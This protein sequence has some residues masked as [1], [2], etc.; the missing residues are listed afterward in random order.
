[1]K[2]FLGVSVIVLLFASVSTATADAK[3][4]RG[5]GKTYVYGLCGPNVC[6][7][8][9]KTRRSKIVL[10]RSSKKEY[11]SIAASPS[12]STLAFTY[13]GELF[14]SGR[15]GRGRRELDQGGFGPSQVAVSRNGRDVSWF[16]NVSSQQ[17]FYDPISGF[18]TCYPVTYTYL[19]RQGLSDRE[20][21]AL[22]GN[23]FTAGWYRGQ[24]MAQVEPDEGTED[25]ICVLDDEGDCGRTLAARPGRA[26]SSPSTSPDGRYL[27]VVSEPA[28]PEEGDMDYEGRIEIF[29]AANGTHIRNLTTGRK[30]DTPIFSPD[31]KSVAFNRGDDVLS[32]SVRGGKQKLIKRDMTLTGPSWARGK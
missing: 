8:D 22:S 1:M 32:R 25:Y 21:D 16:A 27:A 29:N 2:A 31:G 5:G 30:D 6:R 4:K 14:R 18:P 26:Y 20:S 28:P 12:G 17:C 10:R 13:D 7:V 15:D 11:R 23:Q 19:F 3:P 24:L 9:A